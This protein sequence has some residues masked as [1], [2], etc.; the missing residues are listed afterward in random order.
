VLRWTICDRLRA[1]IKEV[2]LGLHP[3]G[4]VGPCVWGGVLSP[5]SGVRA[6]C[7]AGGVYLARGGAGVT[8]DF[9]FFYGR[10]G[11]G[12][13]SH[14][15]GVGVSTRCG[16]QSLPRGSAAAAAMLGLL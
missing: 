9:V 13:W 8:L 5:F 4:V 12:D 3:A 1:G 15:V 14:E 7:D 11:S 10:L 2:A 6:W 16:C